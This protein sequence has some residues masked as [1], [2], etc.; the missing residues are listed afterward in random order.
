MAPSTAAALASAM[1]MGG[2]GNPLD[3]LTSIMTGTASAPMEATGF[4]SHDFEFSA[5]EL[6]KPTRMNK[7]YLVFAC[8]ILE[9]DLMFVVY[10][11][12]TVGICRAEQRA[13]ACQK[14]GVNFSDVNFSGLDFDGSGGGGAP[15]TAAA[16]AAGGGGGRGGGRDQ[17]GMPQQL[18]SRKRPASQAG[19]TSDGLMMGDGVGGGGGELNMAALAAGGDLGA[20]GGMV[21]MQLDPN[22][23]AGLGSSTAA[24]MGGLGAL[25]S[26]G[27]GGGGLSMLPQAALL[28]GGGDAGAAMAAA[29]LTA[30]AAGGAAALVPPLPAT[31]GALRTLLLQEYEA[32]GLTRRLS[33]LDLQVR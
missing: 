33:A 31:R 18:Q 24:N 17:N 23:M 3:V 13:K 22:L 9:Q 4:L 16:A 28:P 15:A 5:V 20:L 25:A 30:G 1:Q 14:L 21:G 27:G 8:S 11:V 2:A 12:P 7:V 10:N 32:A 6:V 19:W 26:L 29:A